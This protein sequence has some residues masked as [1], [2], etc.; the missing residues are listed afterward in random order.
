MASERT[1]IGLSNSPSFHGYKNT[2]ALNLPML[3][4]FASCLA[5]CVILHR[6]Y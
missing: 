6:R 2:V 4:F 3:K 1:D 5:S